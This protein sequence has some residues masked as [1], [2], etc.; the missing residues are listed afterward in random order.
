MMDTIF[1][2]ATVRGR[3]AIG[4]VRISGPE[5]LA[6]AGQ[7]AG[8]LPPP[9]Q[10]G[11]R[12]LRDPETSERLD[13]ALVL[14]FPGPASFTGEDVVEIQTHGSSAVIADVLAA[15]GRIDGLRVAEPGE[16]TRRALLNQRLDLAQ[17]EGLGDLLAAETAV[18]RRQALEMMEGVLSQLVAGWRDDAMTALGLLEATIDFADEEIPE[19]L[20]ERVEELLASVESVMEQELARAWIGERIRDGFEVALVGLPNVGKST[21]LNCVARRDVALVSAEAG[22]TRD[23][24]EVRLDLDGLPV[25]M[26]DMAGLREASGV[27]GAGVMR[28]RERAAAADLR[29]FL[30]GVPDEVERLGVSRQSGDLVVLAKA[31]LRADGGVSGITGQGVDDM[32]RGVSAELGGRVGRRTTMSRVRQRDAVA[33]ALA[34][35]REAR[36]L[37]AEGQVELAAEGLRSALRALDFLVGRVDVEAVLD[38]IFS[39]FCVGK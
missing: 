23:V 13:Q 34:A 20:A 29:V 8:T 11:L 35:V 19:G 2:P 33:R 7:L 5:S 31:D 38:V 25:T 12:W 1:A 30:V 18:Q 24:L 4:V 32:L 17:V 21:L 6:A 9:R 37:L 15:L 36:G 10:A 26:L 14:V 3:S 27:E 16:F 39:N 22:T 28:A